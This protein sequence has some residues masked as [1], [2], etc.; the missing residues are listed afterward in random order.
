[1]RQ[2]FR[3]LAQAA[4][5]RSHD[6]VKPLLW[7]GCCN[8]YTRFK[9]I[10]EAEPEKV[11][12]GVRRFEFKEWGPSREIAFTLTRSCTL[13]YAREY[14]N[15]QITRGVLPLSVAQER[16]TWNTSEYKRQNIFSLS[17]S[18]VKVVQ[19][20]CYEETI[21]WN[22]HVITDWSCERVANGVV[23]GALVTPVMCYLQIKRM[24]F[25]SYIIYIFLVKINSMCMLLIQ[26]YLLLE[27]TCYT[28]NICRI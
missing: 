26:W 3:R 12:F 19:L 13:I 16:Q 8:A 23:D 25:M 22:A 7:E 4:V 20:K 15:M 21:N 24:S 10:Y 28:S 27:H 1:M 5:S 6:A 11:C 17:Q 14:T 9:E 2:Y 18:R